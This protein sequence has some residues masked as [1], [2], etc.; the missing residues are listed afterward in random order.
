[1]AGSALGTPA[2]DLQTLH[3]ESFLTPAGSTSLPSGQAV[4]AIRGDGISSLS[5]GDL[6]VSERTILDQ[7][8]GRVSFVTGQLKVTKVDGSRALATVEFDGA[9]TSGPVLGR[10][11]KVMSGDTIRPLLRTIQPKLAI[12]GEI[13]FAYD[14][15]FLDPN[16]GSLSLELSAAGRGVISTALQSLGE[17]RASTLTVQGFTDKG[18]DSEANQVESFERA[19]TVKRFMVDALG[20]DGDRV[21]AFGLGERELADVTNLAGSARKNR[22][23]VIKILPAVQT[24]TN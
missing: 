18:G 21:H 24:A 15:I 9:E 13:S 11:N 20:F 14:D 7:S 4:L 22:R 8:A 12:T 19:L 23:I 6:L 1:M 16:A 3:V 17:V 5:G 10:F 2:Q